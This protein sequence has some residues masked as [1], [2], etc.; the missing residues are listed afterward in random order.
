M[1]P[2]QVNDPK[3]AAKKQ[4]VGT[5]KCLKTNK[6]YSFI[7]L[8]PPHKF[9]KPGG[10]FVIFE[11]T[12]YLLEYNGKKLKKAIRVRTLKETSRK[13]FFKQWKN[14]IPKLSSKE[15]KIINGL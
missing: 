13:E 11:P 14:A 15:Q 10:N 8:G 6:Y 9:K 4:K 7:Y 3:S 5:L 1:P 2:G 12:K